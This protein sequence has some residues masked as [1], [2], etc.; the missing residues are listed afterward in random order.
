MKSLFKLVVLAAFLL[1]GHAAFA[2]SVAGCGTGNQDSAC[3]T[4]LVKAAEVPPT[5]PTGPGYPAS[6]LPVWEGSHYSSDCSAFQPQPTC[7]G[8]ETETVT[9]TWNGLEWVGLG[10]VPPPPDTPAGFVLAPDGNPYALLVGYCGEEWQRTIL[11]VTT[12]EWS[13]TTSM[14]GGSMAQGSE[15]GASATYQYWNTP[16]SAVHANNDVFKNTIAPAG[17]VVQIVDILLGAVL[18][19]SGGAAFATGYSSPNGST[20][21]GW[22]YLCPSTYPNMNYATVGA[23][24]DSNPS[25]IECAP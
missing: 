16:A 10:C 19:E 21:E 18:Q 22:V 25:L 7:A 23:H 4:P 1:V 3:V 12:F 9:P 20:N 11:R 6:P 2:Q 17:E 13:C 8:G 15:P 24:G 14:A 5:C